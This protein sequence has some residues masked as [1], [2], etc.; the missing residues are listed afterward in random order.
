MPRDSSGNYTLPIGAFSPGGL[1]KSSDMNS[2]FDDIALAL[3]TSI[4]TNGAALIT[5][6]FLAFQGS[7]TNPGLAWQGDIH[8]GFYKAG[9]HQTAW[10]YN[11]IQGG[12]FN[13]DGAGGT[14]FNANVTINGALALTGGLSAPLAV[15]QGGTGVATIAALT[16]ELNLFTSLLQGLVPASGGVATTFLNGA[17]A[18]T[19]PVGVSGNQQLFTSTNTWTKPSTGVIALVEIWG[20]G[21]SG[22]ASL[23]GCPCP[24]PGNGGRGG[25]YARAFF[26]MSALSSTVSITI[27]NGGNSTTGSTGA[28]NSG[29][30]TTFGSFLTAK[31]G[32]TVVGSFDGGG[33]FGG[34]PITFPYY[35]GATG[36]FAPYAGA[37]G[38]QGGAA[39]AGGTS[40]L[41]GNGGAG[42]VTNGVGGTAPGGGGGGSSKTA[43]NTSGA[44]AKG[45]AQ[46]TVF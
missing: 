28:Q 33:G 41:G 34:A 7:V 18:F 13:N 14:L 19:T 12:V 26:L 29:G 3:T 5:A 15:A 23:T 40:I 37:G 35:Q 8:T 10:A 43:A 31:G 44:G 16:A 27:G 17:G 36:Q 11:G 45:Q 9:T 25:S 46:I 20:G 42:T 38:G 2:N 22:A 21:Q 6:P 1:I 4:P 39:N 24:T 30:D 32:G